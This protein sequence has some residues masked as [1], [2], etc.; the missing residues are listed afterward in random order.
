MKKYL[1]FTLMLVPFISFGQLSARFS[2][3]NKASPSDSPTSFYFYCTDQSG[4][5]S[6]N[7]KLPNPPAGGKAILSK[8][9]SQ[10]SANNPLAIGDGCNLNWTPVST[11]VSGINLT[12]QWNNT[13]GH[14]C[15]FVYQGSTMASVVTNSSM[16]PYPFNKQCN[17]KITSSGINCPD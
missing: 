4:V 1:I 17:C 10:I 11:G 13:V 14:V 9:I 16:A 6:K 2:V 7:V 8:P 5:S 15:V 12:Q 3:V